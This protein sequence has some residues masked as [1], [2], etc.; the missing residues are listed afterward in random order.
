MSEIE[1][2][3][4]NELREHVTQFPTHRFVSHSQFETWIIRLME[5]INAYDERPAH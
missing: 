4:L 5:I 3:L 2:N 1:T